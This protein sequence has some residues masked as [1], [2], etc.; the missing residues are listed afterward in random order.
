M[1]EVDEPCGPSLRSSRNTRKSSD[2][3]LAGISLSPFAASFSPAGSSSLLSSESSEIEEMVVDD[4]LAEGVITTSVS[5][6][7]SSA[8]ESE[9][10]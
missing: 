5:T 8:N 2:T 7:G 1:G 3:S 4:A 6:A 9:R 10:R